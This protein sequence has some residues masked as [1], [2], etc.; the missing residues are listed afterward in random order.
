MQVNFCI[1]QDNIVFSNGLSV[2]DSDP[3]HSESARIDGRLAKILGSSGNE[4]YYF[5]GDYE[6]RR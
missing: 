1:R 4:Y 5:A 6:L 3:R 2:H